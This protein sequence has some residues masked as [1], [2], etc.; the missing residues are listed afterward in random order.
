MGLLTNN[1]TLQNYFTACILLLQKYIMKEIS[2]INTISYK[3]NMSGSFTS[4]V[5]ELYF[6]G[7]WYAKY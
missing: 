3:L 1:L 6:C 4:E 5:V 2:V 7:F